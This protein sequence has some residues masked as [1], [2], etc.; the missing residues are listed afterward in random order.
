[1]AAPFRAVYD[2]MGLKC[3]SGK[4]MRR[5]A[6]D[7]ATAHA[8]SALAIRKK[9]ISPKQFDKAGFHPK[10]S[11]NRMLFASCVARQMSATTAELLQAQREDQRGSGEESGT[12]KEYADEAREAGSAIRARMSEGLFTLPA[13][14]CGVEIDPFSVRGL[15]SRLSPILTYFVAGLYRGRRTTRRSRKRSIAAG[16]DKAHVEEYT[17]KIL[18]LDCAY[19]EFNSDMRRIIRIDIDGRFKS[20]KELLRL[21]DELNLPS[22]NLIT[23]SGDGMVRNPHLYYILQHA[24]CFTVNGRPGPQA[25]FKLVSAVLAQRLAPLGADPMATNSLR[26]KNPLCES[27]TTVIVNSEPYSL[28]RNGVGTQNLCDL[29]DIGKHRSIRGFASVVRSIRDG[30]AGSNGLFKVVGWLAAQLV[31]EFH[32]T[33]HRRSARIRAQQA[34]LHQALDDFETALIRAAL[35]HFP[36]TPDLR[37]QCASSAE[38]YF[39]RF[40]PRIAS[41]NRQRGAMAGEPEYL[42][43]LSKQ[44]KQEAGGRYAAL[45]CRENTLVKIA[46]AAEEIGQP[47]EEIGV[48]EL[49]RAAGVSRMTIY[50]HK[51]EFDHGRRLLEE[52]RD[53]A[54]EQIVKP[55]APATPAPV[56]TE[57]HIQCLDKKALDIPEP[58]RAEPSDLKADQERSG[59][60]DK[61]SAQAQRVIRP[62]RTRMGAEAGA[63]T[64]HAHNPV[65]ALVIGAGRDCL[66]PKIVKL[67]DDVAPLAF[68]AAVAPTIAFIDD[69]ARERMG[70]NPVIYAHD[71]SVAWLNP[72]LGDETQLAA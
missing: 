64:V 21:I 24:V 7:F 19:V 37:R 47:A 40:D 27:M 17:S 28:G 44:E 67:R 22:P 16:G 71:G 49:A 48:A 31:H 54:A 43:A 29:L 46:L 57:C 70:K 12:Q 3:A 61:G 25:L 1:M 50:R 26:G 5:Q 6:A 65:F 45:K 52:I 32:P 51:S 56:V 68:E 35:G 66:C 38:Y 9:G 30:Q 15:R 33:S 60:T 8:H 2:P 10:A 42:A 18:A 36:D 58:V 4:K 69:Y 39:S 13:I 34:G 41:A 55:A 20:E 53:R 11:L 63:A 59:S 14:V 62:T 72:D 23:W